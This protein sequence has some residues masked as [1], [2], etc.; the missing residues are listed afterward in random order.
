MDKTKDMICLQIAG[1]NIKINFHQAK[2]THSI[3]FKTKIYKEIQTFFRGFIVKKDKV[4][5]DYVINFYEMSHTFIKKNIGSKNRNFLY[6]FMEKKSNEVITFYYISLSQL[7]IILL[8]IIQKLLADN[9]GFILHAS[10]N[11]I[12][13][14]ALLF[15]APSGGGKSTVA[16]LI[17]KKYN[18]M[19][20]DAII[21]RKKHGIYYCYQT[22]FVEKHA[23]VKKSINKYKINSLYF[24]RKTKYY[25]LEKIEDK[26]YIVT[27]LSRQLLTDEKSSANQMNS[28]LDFVN[29]FNQFYFLHFAKSWI[30][31]L[32]LFD[33]K[34]FS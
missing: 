6:L 27:Y 2:T 31:L 20:D 25:D 13:N 32:K 8:H 24:L 19:A 26:N 1:F 30:K 33:L 15:L 12:M 29:N 28:L 18:I 11:I 16:A 5:I 34:S 14:K 3:F 10:A 22:P 23:Y 7:I 17:N 9:N 4:N 21:V